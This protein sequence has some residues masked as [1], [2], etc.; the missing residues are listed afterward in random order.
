MGETTKQRHSEHSEHFVDAG[1][2]LGDSDRGDKGVTVVNKCGSAAST[3]FLG[4]C[5]VA[6]VLGLE[7]FSALSFS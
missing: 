5:R 4:L 1:T 3:T 6:L 7:Y 2:A